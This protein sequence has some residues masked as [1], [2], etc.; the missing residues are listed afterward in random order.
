MVTSLHARAGGRARQR[1]KGELSGGAHQQRMSLL[2]GERAPAVQQQQ[3]CGVH[4]EDCLLQVKPDLRTESEAEAFARVNS[5]RWRAWAWARTNRSSDSV[6]AACLSSAATAR[7]ERHSATV[8]TLPPRVKP[9][10]P[11]SLPP[12]T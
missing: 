6:P 1:E 5:V 9:I 2:H 4:Q 11:S 3:P 10:S 12:S 8:R 7:R